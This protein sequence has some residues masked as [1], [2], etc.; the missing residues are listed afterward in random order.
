MLKNILLILFSVSLAVFGQVFLKKGMLDIGEIPFNL[1]TPVFLLGK[2]FSNIKLFVGFF[3]FAL[4]SVAW[5]VVLSRVDLSFA[6]PMVSTGYVLT[7]LIS[8]KYLGESVSPA[9]WLGVVIICLGV[10]V[11]SRS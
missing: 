2:V 8:W 9:R 10:V 6:Y 1:G 3:L 5:L 11:L 7:V 4:S